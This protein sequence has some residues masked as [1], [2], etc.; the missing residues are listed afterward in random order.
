MLSKTVLLGLIGATAVSAQCTGPAVNSA[1]LDLVTSFEGF[2][3]DICESNNG[4]S[5][6]R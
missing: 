2:E 6:G 3:P 5:H 1:T 4:S